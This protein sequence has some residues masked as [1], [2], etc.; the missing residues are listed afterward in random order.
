MV[1][2]KPYGFLI[3]YF[4]LIHLVLTLLSI[5]LVIKVNGILG[6]YN[7]FISGSASKLDAISYVTNFYIIVIILSIFIC[8][9]IYA[10]MRYKEKPRLLY[11]LLIVLYFV[12]AVMIRVSYSGLHTIYISVLETK[13]MRLYRD[14]LQIL[15][16]VQY[17][18]IAAVLIRGLGFDIKKFNFVQ[19]LE[20]LGLEVK[21]EEEI[22]L[23]LGGTE[24]TQ[25]K[26]HRNFRELKYY[27]LENKV[28]I[29]IILSFF[30]T[31]GVITFILD[32]EFFHKVY[33]EGEVFSTDNFTF[34]ILDS[35]ITNRDYK[36]AIIGDL[37]HSFVVVRVNLGANQEGREF[38]TSNFILKTEKNSYASEIRYASR[39]NDLGNVYQG[40]VIKGKN[41]YLFLY[42]VVNGELYQKMK[43][44]YAED[45]VVNL[46]PVSLDEKK[47]AI[48]VGLGNKLDLSK[49]SMKKGY[50]QISSY[51]IQE[52]FSYSYNYE[53]R[54]EKYT[55][56]YTISSSQN[57]ILHL[58]MDSQYAGDFSNYEFFSNYSKLMYKIG[59]QEYQSSVLA[60]KTPGNYKKGVYLIVDKKVMEA[61]KI[62]FDIN[63]RNQ[64]YLYVLK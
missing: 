52:R 49:T 31:V 54:G 12:T 17:L 19:D 29:N 62:W 63:I 6:Y 35:Y 1:F 5:F 16:W 21:D 22:E 53:L 45:K 32:H 14:L 2:R 44:V 38:K 57:I 51:E 40:Q 55:G 25:R 56:E 59:E 30:V 48:S 3:K 46:K 42:P 15:V 50:L 7:H 4:K 58:E 20:E 47:D 39:F 11:L 10:L 13:T 9:S 23:T 34:Q 8:L 61:S 27:Y 60:D 33:E 36:G 64:E 43:I 37:E 26:I 28:F 24:V 41:T 18:S